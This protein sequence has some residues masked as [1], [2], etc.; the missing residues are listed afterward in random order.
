MASDTGPWFAQPWQWIVVGLGTVLAA[1]G[2]IRR[3]GRNG[4]EM[5]AHRLAEEIRDDS[6]AVA[7]DTMHD[8]LRAIRGTLVEAHAETRE[9]LTKELADSRHRTHDLFESALAR[10]QAR[11]ERAEERSTDQHAALLKAVEVLTAETRTVGQ[12]LVA[13]LE[14]LR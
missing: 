7:R 2:V 9:A 4:D 13:R 12:A 10:L 14:A 8:A 11:I 6:R 3:G 1:I 5:D